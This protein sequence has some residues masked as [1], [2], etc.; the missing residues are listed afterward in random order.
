MT[1]D[2][3]YSLSKIYTYEIEELADT[4]NMMVEKTENINV[5][6]VKLPFE[7]NFK[8]KTQ[9]FLNKL[10]LMNYGNEFGEKIILKSKTNNSKLICKS[11][12][13]SDHVI[14]LEIEYKNID[15]YKL[16]LIQNSFEDKFNNY[17]IIWTKID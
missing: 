7:R 16:T 11:W 8:I 9:K 13:L 15:N 14:G 2:R 5:E 6:N 4:L 17:E 12:C 3:V 10:S 1:Y